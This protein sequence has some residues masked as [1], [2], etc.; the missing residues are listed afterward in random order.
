MWCNCVS[1]EYFIDWDSKNCKVDGFVG[2]VKC[3]W[4]FGLDVGLM[5]G[6]IIKYYSIVL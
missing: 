5:V 6:R 4:T 1:L 3:Y 2:F